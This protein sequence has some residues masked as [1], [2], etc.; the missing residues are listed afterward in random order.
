VVTNKQLGPPPPLATVREEIEER[1]RRRKTAERYD[2][3]IARLR[4]RALI[5]RKI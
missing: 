4:A 2:R 5:D 3:W 1:V